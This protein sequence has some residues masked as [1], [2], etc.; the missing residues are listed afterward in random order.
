MGF[1][2]RDIVKSKNDDY[3]TLG[4]N[5]VPQKYRLSFKPDLKTF[6]YEGKGEI[7]VQ[8]KSRTKEILL[9]S[10]ELTI[11]SA[12]VISNGVEYNADVSVNADKQEIT[13][14]LEDGIKGNAQI[15]IEFIGIH[16]D[17]MY[18]FYRSKC[19]GDGEQKYMLTSQFEAA[20]AR[21]A[22]PC[23]DEPGFKSSF[24][25]T[26]IVDKSLDCLSN[27]AIASV[28]DIGE[29]MKEVKFAETPIMSTYL[30]YL[31][32]GKYDYVTGKLGD[33]EV[34]VITTPGNEHLAHLPLEYAM[35]F[36][37]VIAPQ[38]S[39]A[40]TAKS[41]MAMKSILGRGYFIPK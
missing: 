4:Q 29:D 34:R 21:N 15:K 8:I 39:I 20:N 11:K 40:P 5:V 13:L 6:K 32:V 7:D 31:G 26:M 18:G 33:T 23:F 9:N 22:F 38:F 1:K 10:A 28:K 12:I 16:N 30:L 3:Q 24:E 27:T 2:I 37:K 14:M 17:N 35:K 19:N 25:V 36:L 41:G